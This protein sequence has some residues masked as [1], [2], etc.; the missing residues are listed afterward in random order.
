MK[1]GNAKEI[2]LTSIE[3]IA[4]QFRSGGFV[5]NAEKEATDMPGHRLHSKGGVLFSPN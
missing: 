1:K 3:Y 4:S 2:D 5:N